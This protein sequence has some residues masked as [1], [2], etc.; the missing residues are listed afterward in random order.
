MG[1]LTAQ[2]FAVPE[3]LD[4]QPEKFSE[5]RLTNTQNARLSDQK[6]EG[7]PEE[8]MPAKTSHQRNTQ[9]YFTTLKVQ[10]MKY[11]KLM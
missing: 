10:G 1:K 5:G 4:M 2:L 6:D 3:T 7:V 8:G 9:I 11:L